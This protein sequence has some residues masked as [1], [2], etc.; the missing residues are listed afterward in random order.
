MRSMFLYILVAF[1]F[2][3]SCVCVLHFLLLFFSFF[4]HAFC[5]RGE[6]SLFTHCRSTVHAL[7][8]GPTLTL[9]RKKIKIKNGSHDIIHTFKNYFVTIFS[10][11]NKISYIQIDPL[12]IDW[13]M[14]WRE[15]IDLIRKILFF[16]FE[17]KV[18]KN[19][20]N[21]GQSLTSLF[22]SSFFIISPFLKQAVYNMKKNPTRYFKKKLRT[23]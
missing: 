6:L 23:R 1:G 17:R 13:L 18:W 20:T 2:K 19:N 5:F 10:V 12:L 11:F 14:I 8:T 7:F 16:F 4:F 21:L 3:L 9:F 15:A 22:Y